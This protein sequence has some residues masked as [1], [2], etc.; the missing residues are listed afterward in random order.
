MQRNAAVMILLLF[1]SAMYIPN[2]VGNPATDQSDIASEYNQSQVY[3][4]AKILF[5]ESHCERG[6]DMWTPGNASVFSALLEAHGYES[7]TNWEEPLNSGIL[8]NFDILCIF[9]PQ[10]ALTSGE[11]TAIHNFVESGGGLLLVGVDYVGYDWDYSPEHLNLISEIYGITFNMDRWLGKC[12]KAD[13]DL[14][15]HDLTY[16]VASIHSNCDQLRGCTLTVESPAVVIGTFKGSPT[17][18]YSQSGSGRVVAV[19]PLAPFIQYRHD[20]GWRIEWDDHYQ[21][22]LN[23]IDWLVGNAPRIVSVP[24]KIV[25]KTGHGPSLS[26][27]EIEE[28][29]IF[30]GVYHDHT[31]RSDGEDSPSTMVNRALETSLD[32]FLISD[33]SYKRAGNNGILGGLDGSAYQERYGLDCQIFIGAEL[34]SIPHTVG[35]PLTENIFTDDITDAVTRIQSQGAIAVLAHPTIGFAYIDPWTKFDSFGYD[36]FEVDCRNYFHAL[37]ESCYSRPFIASNDGH[38]Y[39]N[40]GLV[41]NVAFVNNPS[42]PNGTISVEDLKEAVLD[43]RIV[44][45]DMVNKVIIGRG[46]WVDRLLEVWDQAEAEVEDSE[47]Q[48]DQIEEGTGW[49]A[50][51]HAYL[52]AAKTALEWWNP[53]RALKLA[54][55]VLS[56]FILGINI[57]RSSQ[58]FGVVEPGATLQFSITISNSNPYAVKLNMTPFIVKSLIFEKNPI[59]VEL[60]TGATQTLNMTF[61]ATSF[62]YTSISINLQCSNASEEHMPVIIT[63]GGIIDNLDVEVNDEDGEITIR[64]LR[65]RDDF[66]MIDYAL[67]HYDNGSGGV[68]ASFQNFGDSY[69]LVLGPFSTNVTISFYITIDDILGNVFRIEG[70]TYSVTGLGIT[71]FTEDPVDILLS[72]T[73]GGILVVVL[74]VVLFIAKRRKN[75]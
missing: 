48:L 75:P 61:N 40:L 4:T 8:T 56:D 47:N 53:S 70:G 7:S 60:E 26:P 46:V 36:A 30:N 65:N 66:R 55:E 49:Q 2:F 58:N 50:L 63:T 72:A 43:F 13:G 20:S 35:F 15:E 69:G 54:E 31:T 25:I 17:V 9:F 24:D 51:P 6:S 1:L 16:D 68:V 12:I 39:R 67:L 41:R 19:G 21:F 73:I 34:S 11:V 64:L 44:V 14:V 37:G 59:V 45:L 27:A 3:Q 62:G 52:A 18:A 38:A 5:D 57:T 28:Y 29:Q 10:I 22:S 33:H 42:G 23:V 71:S 32:F 74:V